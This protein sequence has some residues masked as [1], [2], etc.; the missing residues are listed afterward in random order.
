ME[1][2]LSVVE[3]ALM[4]SEEYR[5]VIESLLSVAPRIDHRSL[6][7]RSN[8][9]IDCGLDSL[10]RVDL[11][12]A[13]E[14]RLEFIIPDAVF[15]KMET[16][17]DVALL[18]KERETDRD[19]AFVETVMSFRER[20]LDLS[21]FQPQ[22]PEPEPAMR[23]FATLPLRA[24]AG[25][26]YRRTARFDEPLD[27]GKP[28]IIFAANHPGALDGFLV[29][30]A[31]PDAVAADTRYLIE[32]IRYP[33]FPYAFLRDRGVVVARPNDPIE[34]L[35]TSLTIINQGNNIIVFP[36]GEINNGGKTAIF[37]PGIGLI[38]RETDARIVPVKITTESVHFGKAFTVSELILAGEVEHDV[39]PKGIAEYIRARVIEI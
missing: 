2:Q 18:I 33:W 9:T 3:M 22:L 38:A 19:P 35:K 31:L 8:F 26:A 25:F 16:I 14:K 21:F 5:T 29:L 36:E 15:D 37:K 17:G 6:S 34:I 4:E 28:P 20:M 13:I 7:P 27:N 1:D 30:H 32:T 24:A 10:D 12:S 39:S 23:R 11:L